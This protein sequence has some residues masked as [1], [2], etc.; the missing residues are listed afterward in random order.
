MEFKINADTFYAYTAGKELKQLQ[1]T[2]V[3]VH[4]AALDHSVWALQSR[5]F[6]HHGYNVLAV[7][8]PAHG[9]S[10]GEPLNSFDALSAWLIQILDVLEIKSAALVGHSMGSLIT[11]YAA[12]H[13]PERVSALS[14]LGTAVPMPV[15]EP[16]L[17]AARNDEH[18]GFEMEN[19]WSHYS[20]T[21]GNPLPG[22]WM[23]GQSI[24]LMETTAPGVQYAD[25]KACNDYQT[26]NEDAAKITCPTMI[27]AGRDDKMTPPKAAHALATVIP[28]AQVQILQHCGHAMMAEQPDVVLDTLRDFLSTALAESA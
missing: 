6:A 1:P 3:F 15:A 23:L 10:G 14:L 19:A 18:A 24:R 7:D 26:G 12:A 11:L 22:M 17:N 2:V 21:G 16:F 27:I 20:E 5:Y 9:R 28:G 4:G 13:Y 25:L 8:L